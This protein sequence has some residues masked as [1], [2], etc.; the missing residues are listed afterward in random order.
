MIN[1]E[2]IRD[3]LRSESQQRVYVSGVVIIDGKEHHVLSEVRCVKSEEHESFN[4]GKRFV[5]LIF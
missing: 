1:A 2:L 5:R 4:D 3:L